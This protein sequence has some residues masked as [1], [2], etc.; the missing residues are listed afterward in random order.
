MHRPYLLNVLLSVGFLIFGYYYKFAYLKL[1]FL[2]IIFFPNLDNKGL[3]AKADHYAFSICI[4]FAVLE[5]C[6]LILLLVDNGLSIFV[7]QALFFCGGLSVIILRKIYIFKHS[8][9]QV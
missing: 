7:A 9:K 6:G 3:F 8:A 2:D 4:I 5:L 1:P